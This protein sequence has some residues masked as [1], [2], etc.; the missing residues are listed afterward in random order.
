MDNDSRCA[1]RQRIYRKP[2]TARS[3]R[4]YATAPRTDTRRRL[5]ET[6]A[7]QDEERTDRPPRRG[8]RESL[9]N[10]QLLVGRRRRRMGTR[11]ILDRR[12]SAIGLHSQRQG[13][14]RKGTAM[15]RVDLSLATGKRTVRAHHRPKLRAGTATRQRTGLVAAYGDAEDHAAILYGHWRQTRHPLPH[16]LLQIPAAGTAQDTTGALEFLGTATRR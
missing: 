4:L 5:A 7:R 6:A 14:E 16:P 8:I 11:P 15:D 2:G 1:K 9:R 3:E 12:T 13:T 10:A